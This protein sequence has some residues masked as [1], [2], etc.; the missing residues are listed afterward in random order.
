MLENYLAYIRKSMWDNK[1]HLCIDLPHV[2][3][4]GVV[5]YIPFITISYGYR[6][7]VEAIKSAKKDISK[8]EFSEDFAK[9]N[10]ISTEKIHIISTFSTNNDCSKRFII[11]SALKKQ[12]KVSDFDF[13]LPNE[14][15]A[16]HPLSCRDASRMLVLESKISDKH[17]TDFVSFLRP[18][19]SLFLIIRGLF[20]RA[21][22]R[23]QMT[24]QNTK[25]H[26]IQK[27][28]MDGWA[29]R[30]NSRNYKSAKS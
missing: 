29:L 8:I 20:P 2:K 21:L 13:E 23:W 16:S 7:E 24:E 5:H 3:P 12:M 28:M 26:C 18:G 25:L 30:R 11:N 10:K 9:L 1:W 14:L 19:M 17:I 4:S 6:T 27:Q 15:I 22:T